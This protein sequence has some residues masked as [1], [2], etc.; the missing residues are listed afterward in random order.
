MKVNLSN[1]IV[2]IDKNQDMEIFKELE[3][4]GIFKENIKN[5]KYLKRSIDSRKKNDIKFIYSLEID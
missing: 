3:K 1:I 2:S 4:N 5:L